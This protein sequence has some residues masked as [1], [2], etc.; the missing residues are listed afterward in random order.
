M[1]RRYLQAILEGFDPAHPG[2][3]SG[4]N[5][6]SSVNGARMLDLA[7]VHVYAWDARPYPAF[8]NLTKIWGDGGNWQLGHWIT[9]RAASAPLPALVG[10]IMA[11]Y[12]FADF[13]ASALA[14]TAPGF[15]IDR[16]MSARDALQPLELAFF[17]DALESE[18]RIRFQ[19]RSVAAT[20]VSLRL[21][22][23][24]RIGPVLI[25]CG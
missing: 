18:G 4:L 11:D 9:G 25:S 21:R 15:V 13:D 7:H 24:S 23:W 2:Y 3:V 17:F 22:I 5:P 20:V 10:Q 6:V 14:G 16:I 12:E 19:P 1:Q 8:P